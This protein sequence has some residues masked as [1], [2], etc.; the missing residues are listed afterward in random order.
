MSLLELFCAVD[1][2][3]IAFEPTWRQQLLTDGEKRRQRTGQLCLSE[4]MTI[5]IHFHHSH[6]R[7]FKSY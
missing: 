5:I 7:H 3:W 4:V 1:D 6:Y 2:F